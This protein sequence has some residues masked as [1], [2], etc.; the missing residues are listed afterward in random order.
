MSI[1]VR[2][3]SNRDIC[4]PVLIKWRSLF[5]L[6]PFNATT[7]NTLQLD[8]FK[9]L[10]LHSHHDVF[11]LHVQRISSMHI[12]LP[13]IWFF[14]GFH[15]VQDQLKEDDLLR[16]G[17][18]RVVEAEHVVSLLSFNTGEKA[19]LKKHNWGSCLII[20]V[21]CVSKNVLRNLRVHAIWLAVVT[22]E[23]LARRGRDKEVDIQTRTIQNLWI[24]EAIKIQGIYR[25]Q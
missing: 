21:P 25:F 14:I 10:Q 19:G 13:L 2:L 20:V 18:E 23:Y 24:V 5:A 12:L 11:Q 9:K 1:W 17:A 6:F 3:K 15:V 16:D 8:S 22:E 7:T 4:F